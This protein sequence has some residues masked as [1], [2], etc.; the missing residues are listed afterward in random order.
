MT[1]SVQNWVYNGFHS[2]FSC[3]IL[4]RFLPVSILGNAE[5]PFPP[6]ESNYM[7]LRPTQMQ[8]TTLNSEYGSLM[9]NPD[10]DA[11]DC[12]TKQGYANA[13]FHLHSE[14][15]GNKEYENI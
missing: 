4:I 3:A 6:K 5:V 15:C 11:E 7:D 14:P 1:F 13:S 8:Q 10:R 2:S 12:K 9:K